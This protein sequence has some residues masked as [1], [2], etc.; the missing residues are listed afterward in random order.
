MPNYLIYST[1]MLGEYWMLYIALL[2]GHNFWHFAGSR[3]QRS[4]CQDK[5]VVLDDTKDELEGVDCVPV[6]KP[7]LCATQ[8]MCLWNLYGGN[9]WSTRHVFV[10]HGCPRRQQSQNMAKISQVL[11][12]DPAP[13]Q[14]Y[15]RSMKCEELTV[16]VW[17][18]Y[19]HPNF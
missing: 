1:L 8:G 11:H 6:Y 12:F 9:S 14:G 13:P 16:Q 4:S 15:V 2:Y 7:E 18:L 5:G 3:S 19:H 10:K 17:W